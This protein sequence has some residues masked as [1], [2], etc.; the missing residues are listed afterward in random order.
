MTPA[1]E[2]AGKVEIRALQVGEYDGGGGGGKESEIIGCGRDT[3]GRR[4]KSGRLEF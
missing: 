4:G 1:R 3:V 2:E